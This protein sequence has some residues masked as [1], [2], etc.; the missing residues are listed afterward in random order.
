MKKSFLIGVLFCSTLYSWGKANDDRFI[1][2][3]HNRFLEEHTLDD[4]HPE[5]GRTE[6]NE[7]IEELEN[8]GFKVISEKRNGYVNAREYAIGIVSKIDSLISMG[9]DPEKITVVG[10]SKGGYIAQYVSTLANNPN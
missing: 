2:F 8:G 3:L 5:F 9:T 7:I 4:L 6:Y 10:T 1:F